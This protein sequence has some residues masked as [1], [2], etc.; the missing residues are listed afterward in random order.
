M[1]TVGHGLNEKR[2]RVLYGEGLGCRASRYDRHL[3]PDLLKRSELTAK[4][5]KKE[6]EGLQ[7]RDEDRWDDPPFVPPTSI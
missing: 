5:P 1:Y 2:Q 3:R 4:L 6:H 7:K